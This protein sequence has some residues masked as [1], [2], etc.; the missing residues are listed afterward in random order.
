MADHSV[1]VLK[2]TVDLLILRALA[3]QPTHGYGVMRWIEEA[4]GSVIQVD[5]GSLYPALYRLERQGWIAGRPGQLES[6]RTVTFY[7][8]TRSG[9]KHLGHEI[10]AWSRLS[11]GINAA[12]RST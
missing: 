5:E 4:T 12:I 10:K 9:R 6:G 11:D 2:G 1:P 3:V 7:A 8:L